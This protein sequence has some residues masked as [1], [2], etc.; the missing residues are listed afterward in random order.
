MLFLCVVGLTAFRI[1]RQYHPGG[2]YDAA[3]GGMS[4]FHNGAYYPAAALAKGISP[5]GDHFAAT[6][7]VARAAPPFSPAMIALHIPFVAL[8]LPAADV[9]Y[10]LFS[11]AVFVASAWLVAKELQR[12]AT[13]LNNNSLANTSLPPP[14]FAWEYF[15]WIL[16]AIIAS[17][18]G[19]TTLLNGYFTPLLVLGTTMAL[20]LSHRAPLWAGVGLM[21]A[22]SKPNYA[23]PLGLLML[24]RGNYRSLTLGVVL[25]IVAGLIPAWWLASHDSWL[26]L[27][28]SVKQGQL[29]HMTDP[30]E[31]PVNTWTRL[32]LTAILAKWL[33]ANP[34]EGVQLGWMLLW[35]VLPV[36][37]LTR[38][39]QQ[40][41]SEGVTS[42]SGL[43]ALLALLVT[44]YHQVYD[45]LILIGP[46]MALV[47]QGSLCRD[48]P[49]PT[50]I[51]VGLMILT[52]WWN[53]FGSEIGMRLLGASELAQKTLTSVNGI[54]LAISLLFACWLAF[55]SR[56]GTN[57]ASLGST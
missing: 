23:I 9:A 4:D 2:N 16:T 29:A 43:I 13:L 5:Y 34:S 42:L 26:G 50:R 21:L 38:R 46:F 54:A 1:Y 47:M 8:G 53:Y 10:Y 39:K 30:R 15:G 27:I 31:L 11:L 14:R 36:I 32:D 12:P 35:M 18:G 44:F 55:R 22:A 57:T 24:A 20:S 49:R 41:D 37:A 48:W 33:G 52:S 40:G 3:H 6:Y 45:A 17:R 56:T 19:H 51:L 7:P 25:S 28:E